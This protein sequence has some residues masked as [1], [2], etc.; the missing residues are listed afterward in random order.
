[1]KM[2]ILKLKMLLF[3]H[4]ADLSLHR[5]FFSPGGDFIRVVA[6]EVASSPWIFCFLKKK[7]IR[8]YTVAIDIYTIMFDFNNL[9][10]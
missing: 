6:G 9:Y 1:M 5:I 2:F 4:L 7:N 10:K 8:L 3:H